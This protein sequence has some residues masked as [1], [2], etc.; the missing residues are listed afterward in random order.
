MLVE[1]VSWLKD[2]GALVVAGAALFISART[3]RRAARK[4]RPYW[5][6]RDSITRNGE[7]AATWRTDVRNQGH[8]V[9][10]YV[11]L[12]LM[13]Q[14]QP[15]PQEI[16]IKPA[17]PLG[18]VINTTVAVGDMSNQTLESLRLIITW[19]QAPDF[20]KERKQSFPFPM[21]NRHLGSGA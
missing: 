20:E 8:G 13:H 3:A 14:L 16:T 17:V 15:E 5:V 11:R 2:W 6:M 9:A 21:L 7:R 4:D 10:S 18:E 1:F 12:H 19:R